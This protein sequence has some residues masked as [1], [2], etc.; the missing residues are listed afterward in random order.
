MAL[1]AKDGRFSAKRGRPRVDVIK[2]ENN[3]I[4]GILNRDF[5]ESIFREQNAIKTRRKAMEL[6]TFTLGRVK[7]ALIQTEK[8]ENAK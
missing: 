5:I 6:I 7:E 1:N 2:D 8:E 3:R 4:T